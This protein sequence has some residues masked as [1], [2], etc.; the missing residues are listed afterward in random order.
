MLDNGMMEMLKFTMVVTL[1]DT[2]EDIMVT[3]VLNLDTT[4]V[5]T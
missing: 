1:K 4:V 2:T 3:M 5:L